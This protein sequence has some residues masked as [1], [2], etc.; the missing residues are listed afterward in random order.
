MYDFCKKK[1]KFV[2][3]LQRYEYSFSFDINPKGIKDLMI[4]SRDFYAIVDPKTGLWIKDWNK[5]IALID[6]QLY[7]S[8]L[9][10]CGEALMND[11]E[12]GPVIN[13]I[14]D[15]ENHQ[16]DKW[17]KFCTKDLRDTFVPLNQKV[18]F[19]NSEI[20]RKDYVTTHL[21]YPLQEG[22]TPYYDKLVNV[23]YLPEERE[24]FEWMI[25]CILAGDQSKVQKFFIFYGEPGS[26][27]STIIGKVIVNTVFGGKDFPY[28]T[29]FT[30]ELLAGKDSFGTGFLSSDPVLAFDDD[31][32]LSRIESNTTLN[33]I[34]SH[35]ATRVNDK[36][37]RTYTTYPNCFLVCG[38]N[39]PVQLDPNSGLLRRL[40]DIRPT[41]EKLEPDEYDE[42]ID[43]LPFEAP[44]IAY[45]CLHV[46]KSKGK[47][48]YNHYRPED[49]LAR[50]S[51]FHNFI[52]D[53]YLRLK[54]GIS[55]SNAY[56]LYVVYA[57]KNNLK[58][59]MSSYKFRDNMKLYFNSYEDRFFSGFKNERIGMK[60][61]KK[62]EKPVSIGW[63]DFKEQKSLFDELYS[64]Q[65]AQYA[66]DDGSPKLRWSSV[67][68][69]LK[70]IDTSK[71]HYVQVPITLIGIDFDLKDSFGN[72]SLEKNLE[73]AN[74]FPPTYAELS[75]SGNGIH[76]HYIYTGGDPNDLSRVYGDNIE[77]KV[78]NGNSALRRRLTKCNNLPISEISSALPLKE[79]GGKQ[80]LEDWDGWK[81]VNVLRSMIIKNL[82]KEY[83]SATKPSVY[84]IYD[85]L[86][87][88]KE[89]GVSYDLRKLSKKVLDFAS[90]S[91]HNKSY[92]TDLVKKMSF[93]SD[94]MLEKGDLSEMI[95]WN[96]Y[97]VEKYLRHEI[98]PKLNV[99]CDEIRSS[100]DYIF[101]LLSDTYRSGVRY[102][103]RDLEQPIFGMALMAPT[104]TDYCVDLVG[105]MHFCSEDVKEIPEESN[106]F[107]DAPIVFIDVES[108]PEDENG[109]ALFL[110]CWKYRGA[111]QKCYRMFN[112]KP[113][114]VQELFN[115]RLVGHNIRDYDAPMLY[116][117]SQGYTAA[118]L[119]R[120][121]QRI[122]GGDKTAQFREAKN[123]AWADTLDFASAANKQ[124]LKKWEI[125]FSKQRDE[126]GNLLYPECGHI[127]M[128]IPWDKSAPKEKWGEIADYCC[129]DV[130]TTEILFDYLKPDFE[131]REI[132]SAL[133]GLPIICTTNQHTTEILVGDIKDP[134]QYYI[135]TDLSKIFD[136][137]EFN[138]FGID[139][140]RYK[141][142]AKIVSGKSIY[143]GIDPGEGGRKI[144]YPGY[145]ENVGLFDVASMHPSS[146]IKLNVFGDKITKRLK[147]LKDARV[148][149][150]HGDYDKAIKLLGKNVEK[151]LTGNPEELKK[152]SKPVADALKTAINSVYGL[153]SASFDNKLRDPRNKD[154]IVAKYGALFMINL[155]EEVTNRGY[156]V[157]HVST[158]SIKVANVD[159]DIVKFIFKYG[160]DY[161]Y[162]F[163]YEKLYSKMCLI[164]DA[165]YIAKVAKEDGKDVTPYWSATGKQFAVPYVFKSLFSHEEIIFDD[166]CETFSVKEGAIYLDFNEN[167]PDVTEQEALLKKLKKND[168]ASKEEID[169]ITE[170]IS[171]GHDYKF[172]GRVGQ[173]TPVVKGIG[174]AI[175][176]RIKDGKSY[177]IQGTKGYRWLESAVMR[178]R[179]QTPYVD[180]EYYR[181]L[182]DDAKDVISEYCDFESF[183]ADGIENYINPPVDDDVSKYVNDV[184]DGKEKIYE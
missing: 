24:K 6:E 120:L 171:K 109:E 163:E 127:E 119:N 50:T 92:C 87:K 164:N 179:D 26:G 66:K 144:G 107:K 126:N 62:E 68:T 94:D 72:K 169:T 122:I 98:V 89:S 99:S 90:K 142:G 61:V 58:T 46:Y 134:K 20:S 125:F 100:I 177:A 174:G 168:S 137:Y 178:S 97:E 159:D 44:G 37:A 111:D 80:K 106:D 35:E 75:K 78:F 85:L 136:G 71:E 153:T 48:Y 145:Y 25:G 117:A 64:E 29:K 4:R 82:D 53:E 12:H 184:G 5:A 60:E 128:E 182:V 180:R 113:E 175:L 150:K 73:A 116:A 170:E 158:D 15:T 130:R 27:K 165:V 96:T 1:K 16:I 105:R 156:K 110:V 141:E 38:T 115:F 149:I 114:E 19:S 30:S 70:D 86:T 172:V 155:E 131:A 2:A 45:R 74:K 121:S 103:L 167:L 143:K 34:V 23:L 147:N 112:P 41:G 173:F 152:K 40:I 151:Y 181:K 160:K 176:N 33:K 139:K 39:E 22:P 138:E 91:T 14:R 3:K 17:I 76:L 47:N 59:K 57:D 67:K 69:K 43:H 28:C 166:M 55:L 11:P 65:P 56:D 148:A 157:V 83:H 162:D 146:M 154:N 124:G 140:S 52:K 32:D 54:D 10:E 63:L 104:N 31:A 36:Y 21:N 51:P 183:V 8:V 77:V 95:E 88:A 118:E 9:E 132:L 101:K 161:G 133:S 13:Y 102:D 123:L 135:Y 79:K 84:Y 129:N 18:K 81:N 93:C 7:E 108:Y 49:M 42:C